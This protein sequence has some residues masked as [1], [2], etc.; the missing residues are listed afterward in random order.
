MTS[1]TSPALT[2]SCM[3]GHVKYTSTTLPTHLTSCYCKTCRRL[4]GAPFLTFG[5]FPVTALTFT[6]N[7][8]SRMFTSYSGIAVRSHCRECGSPISMQ[9]KCE[10]ETIGITVGS[11]EEESVRGPLPR[12]TSHIFVEGGGE[13]RLKGGERGEEKGD[14]EG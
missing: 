14:G 2:G 10:P 12:V 11:I 5:D 9:Y 13:G 7:P 6:S 3:C 1:P 4:S 8:S